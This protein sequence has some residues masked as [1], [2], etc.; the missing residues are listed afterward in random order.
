VTHSARPAPLSQPE[1]LET[2]ARLRGMQPAPA[3]RARVLELGSAGGENLLPLAD[4]YPESRFVGIE[5]SATG[6]ESAVR[7]AREAGLDNIEFRQQDIRQ[8]GPRVGTFDYIIAHNVYSQAGR[9]TR[10]KLLAVCRDHLAAQGIAYVSYKTYPGWL[11]HHMLRDMMIYDTRGAQNRADALARSRKLLDFLQTSLVQD[12]PYDAMVRSEAAELARQDDESLWEHHLAPVSHPVYFP[13][14]VEHA[15]SYALKLAGDAAAGIRLID[16][17]WPS[18]ER[19]LEAIN[20]DALSRELFRDVLQNRTQRQSLLCHENVPVS[21]SLAPELLRGLYLE[22]ALRPELPDVNLRDTDEVHFSSPGGVRTST[23][24]PLVKAAL[25]HLGDVWPDFVRFEDLLTAACARYDKVSAAASTQ[26][27]VARLEENLLHC[28][29]GGSV[30]LHSHGPS[31]VSRAADAPLASPLA[32]LQARRGG[33]VAN[34]RHEPV[35]LDPFDRHVLELL[36]GTRN[37]A[38]M[39][40]HLASGV[41]QGRLIALAHEQRLESFDD[42][43]RAFTQALPDALTRLANSAL[44]IG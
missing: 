34:R 20:P 32:R 15:Q 42:A 18:A 3:G 31:F 6:I 12:H 27:D 4:R 8:L 13:Q 16:S 1:F 23:A 29:L 9:P 7:T 35:E 28:C 33:P 37:R 22:G 36:D 24:W 11:V 19:Q 2:I 14:F 25:M 10:D 38:E 44:L 30:R 39:V 21:S 5:P 41:G 17:L 43:Q 40:E 26:E